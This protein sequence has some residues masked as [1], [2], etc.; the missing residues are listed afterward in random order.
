MTINLSRK[1]K[2]NALLF[3]KATITF[4]IEYSNYSNFFIAENIAGLLVMSWPRDSS[5]D[6]VSHYIQ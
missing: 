1:I 4:L 3:D 2:I 6:L 5:R